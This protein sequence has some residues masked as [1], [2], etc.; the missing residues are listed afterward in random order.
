[1]AWECVRIYSLLNATYYHDNIINDNLLF[2]TIGIIIVN[3][4]N[5][6]ISNNKIEAGGPHYNSILLHSSNN[7]IISGNIIRNSGI[8]FYCCNNN[9][10]IENRISTCDYGIYLYAVTNS[11]FFNMITRNVIYS[12][13][14]GICLNEVRANIVFE[15]NF[16]NNTRD[17]EFFGSSR[18]HFIKNY[19]DR[20]RILPKLIFGYF[21][22]G[23]IWI[24]WF[25]IDWRPALRP[26]DI[27]TGV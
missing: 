21:W 2:S 19:W 18:N 17:V 24:P 12:N 10:I 23:Y 8:L 3:S 22:T 11:C 13:D 15:N 25:N 4:H 5:N 9:V 14:I 20:P 26:Y 7:N 27:P 16:L 6:I 1:V